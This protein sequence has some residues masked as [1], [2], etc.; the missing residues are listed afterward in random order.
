MR[1]NFTTPEKYTEAW[2]FL[3]V[4]GTGFTYCREEQWIEIAF[5]EFDDTNEQADTIARLKEIQCM[6]LNELVR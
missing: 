3:M 6:S 2:K 1:F 4:I 5:D